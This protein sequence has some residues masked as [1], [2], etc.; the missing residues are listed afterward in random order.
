MHVLEINDTIRKW[1]VK[2]DY[3]P[4]SMSFLYED[5]NNFLLAKKR[6]QNSRGL[7]RYTVPVFPLK[8]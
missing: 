1:R 7:P 6:E 3:A 2:T 8:D 5:D 4:G